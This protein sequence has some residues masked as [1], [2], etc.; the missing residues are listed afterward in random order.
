MIIWAKRE[1]S[2]SNAMYYFS[3]ILFIVAF[4]LI[5]NFETMIN[6]PWRS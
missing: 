4:S 5:I 3:I 6:K 2:H 1:I